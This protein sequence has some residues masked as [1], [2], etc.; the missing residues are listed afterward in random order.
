MRNIRAALLLLALAAP[1]YA[2]LPAGTTFE[3][4]TAGADT[5]G[6]CFVAGSSG[7]DYTQQN[8]AQYSGTNL[9]VDLV[10]NT[11]VTSASHNFVA[12]DVGD[13]IHVTAGA[14]WTTGYYQIVSTASNAATLDRSPAAVGVTNGTFAVG[15]ALLTLAGLNGGMTGNAI[16]WV[17]ADG[18]YSIA[19][20]ITFNFAAS[21]ASFEQ[22][23]GYTTTRGDNGYVTIRAAN[24]LNIL[25]INNNTSSLVVRNFILDCNGFA[26]C[27]GLTLNGAGSEGQNI[28]VL[29]PSG[30]QSGIYF[31]LQGG[32][33]M[34]SVSGGTG[35]TGGTAAINMASPSG[36]T[37]CLYCVASGNTGGPG[38]SFQNTAIC[39]RCISTG[40][41]VGFQIV[42]ASEQQV[43]LLN[44]VAWNNA[45]DGIKYT[46][47]SSVNNRGL[48]I[49]GI[50]LVSNGG[51]GFDRT[52]AAFK[53][54]DSVIDYNAYYGNASGDR[55]NVYV[56][57]HDVT[58]TADPFTNAAIGDFS[59]NSL[60]GG[61]AAAKGA[62]YPGQFIGLSTLGHLDLGATQSAGAGGGGNHVGTIR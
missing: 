47:S 9:T 16:A 20:G 12:A 42:N 57:P 50:L 8:A 22:I 17:K 31:S 21:G 34:C 23:N 35:L 19:T 14:G 32:C 15:G 36:G 51:Y 37:V 38:F 30:A 29:R 33:S 62:G 11:I 46:A 10:T 6:G 58:L 28:Q 27:G 43:T 2:T 18:V 39:D 60:T 45:G 13:C 3:V 53:S 56:A 4:R 59:L 41:A 1:V 48:Q 61:G 49:I 55:Y 54:G 40:N 7:T 52:D 26:T 44:G 5:N 25:T 24:N